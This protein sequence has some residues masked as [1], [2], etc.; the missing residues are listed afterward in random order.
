MMNFQDAFSILNQEQNIIFSFRSIIAR[1]F[2]NTLK[3]L[4]II[5][6]DCASNKRR[7]GYS[8]EKVENK[9]LGFVYYARY[10]CQGKKIKFN[11][12]T[13]IKEEAEKFASENKERLIEQYIRSHDAKMYD[14]L[15]RFYAPN[16]EYLLCE[17]K[18]NH[19]ISERCRKDYY[20]I[21]NNK[22]VPFL[23][24]RNVKG[25]AEVTNNLLSDYQDY[26]L[27]GKVKPQTANN[28]YKALKRIFKYAARKGI[29]KENPC[30]SVH[31]I[32]VHKGDQTARGCH[33]L[34]KLKGA[35]DR[36]WKD[37]L[38]YLLCLIIYTTGLRNSEIK[39]VAMDDIIKIGNCNFID[40]KESKTPS[41]I[42]MVP[43]HDF[44]YKKIYEYCH[45]KGLK[46]PLFCGCRPETFAKANEELAK[47]IKVGEEKLKKE[48]ITFYSGRHCWKTMMNA[49]GLGEDIE[50]VFM[51][52]TV[53][54][55]VAKLYNHRDKQGKGRV[56]AKAKQV[57]KIIDQYILRSDGKHKKA[58][59]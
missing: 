54:G 20:A 3:A 40:I 24:E 27:K 50:E 18:R 33:E 55:N 39:R 13:N 35:F 4:K 43:L 45:K 16:S 44:T 37:E 6:H 1:E 28:N 21:I 10:S 57:Y 22:F 38:S 53:S 17:E 56:V 41:G 7:K 32:P 36:K 12:R 51:G 25:F 23:K 15:E 5:E 34:E 49:G 52:H 14:I 9:K 46:G 59:A 31:Y 58:P 2:P 8:L 48:N 30:E 26:L 42:R 47:K 29:V 11:T 19:T